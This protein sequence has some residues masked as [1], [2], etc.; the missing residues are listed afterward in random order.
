MATDTKPSKSE[1]DTAYNMAETGVKQLSDRLVAA[2]SRVCD[3]ELAR[4][5]AAREKA[6]EEYGYGN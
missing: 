4:I 1:I 5:R 3:E 2:I 6:L